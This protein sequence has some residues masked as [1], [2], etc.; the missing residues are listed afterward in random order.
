MRNKVNHILLLV[1]V[2]VMAGTP[3]L[4]AQLAT[5]TVI[6]PTVIF[7]GIPKSYEI[8][9]IRITGADNYEEKNI[10]GYSGLKVGDYIP[11]PGSDLTDA[12]KRLWRQGLFSKVQIS[13]DKVSGNKAWLA[14]NLRQQ[15]RIS[16]INYIGVK[17]GE[18]KDLDEALQLRRG[19]QITQNIVNRAEQIIS[20]YYGNKGFG[21]AKVKIDLVED[22][23]APNEVR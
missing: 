4:R 5:D 11:I 15:P 19:N 1:I 7:S 9:G 22:L 17:K 2:M 18:Q 13:V 23:S 10:I 14:F 3:A 6:N 8:A 21:N 16:S 20:K 12:A